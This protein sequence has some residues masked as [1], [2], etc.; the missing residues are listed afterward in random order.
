MGCIGGIGLFLART[1]M[2]VSMNEK[3]DWALLFGEKL[4]LVSF[5]FGFEIVLR[6]LQRLSIDP[7]SGESRYPLL[8]PVYFCLITPVFY[9]ILRV[10]NI[11][12]QR[13]TTIGFFFPPIDTDEEASSGI[14]NI[15]GDLFD[16]W[17][18]LDIR[19]ISWAAVWDSIPTIVA[20]TLFSL[21][22]V[23]INIPAVR[24]K[25]TDQQKSWPTLAL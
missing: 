21:I 20:L 16:L 10:L 19:S 23:P 24:R 9:G 8:S 18:V 13:A 5:V 7:V 15:P 3:F 17:S 1:A 2:E 14:L 22:H 6:V 12:I 25:P 4:P 11:S